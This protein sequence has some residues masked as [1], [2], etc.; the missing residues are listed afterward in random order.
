MCLWYEAV[1]YR[2]EILAR[3]PITRNVDILE[4]CEF[5][6]NLIVNST[7]IQ[8]T[9]YVAAQAAVSRRQT[10]LLNGTIG[11]MHKSVTRTS[12]SGSLLSLPR[13]GLDSTRYYATLVLCISKYDTAEL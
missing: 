11:T 8:E 10:S 3:T 9:I 2:G 5:R 7:F 13:S 12:R 6:L 1:L 4:S